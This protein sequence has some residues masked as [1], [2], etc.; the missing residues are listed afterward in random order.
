MSGIDRDSI[1]RADIAKTYFYFMANGERIYAKF[2]RADQ[3]H[4]WFFTNNGTAKFPLD[5]WRG[6]VF[7]IKNENEQKVAQEKIQE[8]KIKLL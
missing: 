1:I 2:L 8:E 7:E 5:S 3:E 6:C 4:I